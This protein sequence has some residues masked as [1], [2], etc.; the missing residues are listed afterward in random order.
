MNRKG[1]SRVLGRGFGLFRQA[2]RFAA[3]GLMAVALDGFVFFTLLLLGVTPEWA[4]ATGF[5]CA[6]VF[7]LR[8]LIPQVFSQ[9]NT[10]TRLTLMTIIY[11][12][13]GVLNVAIFGTAMTL[14]VTE[15]AAFILATAAS[16]SL[17]FI[18]LKAVL[19]FSQ[20]RN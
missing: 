14:G 5:L 15:S 11:G 13:T 18:L 6:V 12:A 9:D 16:A 3:F 8:F 7:S 20:S 2:S 10:V 17:N 19:F 1:S 4:K